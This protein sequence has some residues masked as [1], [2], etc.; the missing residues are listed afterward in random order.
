[1]YC[2]DAGILQENTIPETPQ[3]N[4]L[5]ERCYRKLLEM[6]RFL[7][8]ASGLLKMMWGAEIL[9]A[10]RIKNLVVRRGEEKGLAELMRG[11]KLELSFSKLFIFCCR[12]FMRKRDKDVRK[13]EPKELEWK[14]LGYTW[15]RQRIPGVCTQQ[16]QGGDSSRCNHQGVRCGLNPSQHRD[17]GPI[18]WGITAAGDLAPRWCSS[19]QWQKRETGHIYCN[20]R[21][22]AWRREREHLRN[23]T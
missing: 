21:S 10:T 3:Q 17:A 23:D 15:R 5:D 12:V 19:R 7:L 14:F 1:M 20:E 6:A 8:I 4:G 13:L 11:I 9:P 22:V 16:T 2:L 18:R